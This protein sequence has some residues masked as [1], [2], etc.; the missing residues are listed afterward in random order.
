MELSI[1]LQTFVLGKN[2]HVGSDC[3]ID[4]LPDWILLDIDNYLHDT[5]ISIIGNTILDPH[6]HCKYNVSLMIE[7]KTIT[8]SRSHKLKD[9]IDDLTLFAHPYERFM[10]L[11]E[12]LF[13]FRGCKFSIGDLNLAQ[14]DELK[15][16]LEN[17]QPDILY[18]RDYKNYLDKQKKYIFNFRDHFV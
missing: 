5:T 4:I 1:E 10:S 11:K 6:D 3:P 18:L 14:I 2:T 15:N 17:G 9:A 8:L 7:T 13:V 16:Y 12:F